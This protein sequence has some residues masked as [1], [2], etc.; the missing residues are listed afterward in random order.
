MYQPATNSS[1]GQ[2]HRNPF[3]MQ[4]TA[5]AASSA[6]SRFAAS[7]RFLDSEGFC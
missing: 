2:V 6:V 4:A 3:A 7:A 5:E 1:S